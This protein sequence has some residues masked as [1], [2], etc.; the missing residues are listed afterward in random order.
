MGISEADR[1]GLRARAEGLATEVS[2]LKAAARAGESEAAQALGDAKLLQE[3][4]RLEAEKAE[5]LKRAEGTAGTVEDAMRAMEEAAAALEGAPPVVV[6]PEPVVPAE[7]LG[8]L[9]EDA[10][11]VVLDVVPDVEGSGNS[12]GGES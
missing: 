3:I 5:V 12:E 4:A 11:E 6:A 8:E 7:P 10:S 2:S 9:V 1:A